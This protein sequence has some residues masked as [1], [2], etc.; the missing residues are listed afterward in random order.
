MD[1]VRAVTK[2][3]TVSITS[4]AQFLGLRACANTCVF[5]GEF[6]ESAGLL[7]YIGCTYPWYDACYCNTA[8]VPQ[9][10]SFVSSC[11]SAACSEVNDVPNAF[12]V[13]EGYCGS[14]GFPMNN[15]AQTTVETITS[16]TITEPTTLVV[17]VPNTITP[18]VTATTSG[19]FASGQ[20]SLG[21]SSSTSSA[22]SES[23]S[24]STSASSTTPAQSNVGAIAGGVV[25]GVVAIGIAAVIITM[26]ILRDRRRARREQRLA[27]VQTWQPPEGPSL[28]PPQQVVTE[29][30][31]KTPA[32]AQTTPI[33]RA[34]E[35]QYI[36][37]ELDGRARIAPELEGLGSNRPWSNVPEM[38]A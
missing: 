24:P 15:I 21:G 29:K 12:S 37:P 20:G 8:I 36:D 11:I 4:N 3:A 31:P 22:N 35:R 32:M 1:L 38:Q 6:I 9:A 16:G 7:A 2:I 5:G 10:S 28:P 18:T 30:I 19:G 23:Q 33:Y 34:E 27:P 25:G 26:L 17:T 14:A 13:W